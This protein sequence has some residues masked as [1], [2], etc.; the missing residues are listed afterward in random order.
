MRRARIKSP[1]EAFYHI[2]TRVAGP[3]RYFP[4]KY[5]NASRRLL[6]TIRYYVRAYCCEMAAY[7]IMGNHYHLILFFEEYRQLSRLELQSRARLVY[8]RRAELRTGPWSEEAWQQFN[9]KLFDL[10][11][12][13]QHI[14]GEYAKWFNQTFNRRGHFWA[15][16]FKNPELL[17]Q[18]A[19]QECLL[20][21]ELN[22]L[23][24][25]LVKRPEKWRASSA[26]ARWRGQDQDLM[27]LERIFSDIP[28]EIVSEVY[29]SLLYER[30]GISGSKTRPGGDRSVQ[31][32]TRLRFFSDGLAIG[33]QQTV[34]KRIEQLRAKGTYRHRKKPIAQLSGFLFTV[35]EQRAHAT[36]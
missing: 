35:R 9:R 24:A 36:S 32:L 26:W 22:A 15:D 17:D 11:A 27:P 10:S 29:R 5:R 19:L 21:V 14:N 30:G 34:S 8:G 7:K 18:E 33:N 16:R 13:M 6:E 3:P 28:K 31:F 2:L 25:H 20:Y 4:L 23:R 12:L 1:N